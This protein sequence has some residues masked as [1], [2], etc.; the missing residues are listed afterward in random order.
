MKRLGLVFWALILLALACG[1]KT[2]NMVHC[3]SAVVDGDD[4]W[5]VQGTITNTCD[6]P[7]RGAK[8][9]LTIKSIDGTVLGRDSEI[10]FNVAPGGHE[11]VEWLPLAASQDL[12]N[13]FQYT[14]EIETAY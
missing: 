9:W 12:P 11:Y 1:G 13:Q 4:G 10:V 3:V 2:T 6:Q 14:V 8:V 7:L 5:A